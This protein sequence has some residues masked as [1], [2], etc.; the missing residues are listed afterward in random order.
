M[1][2]QEAVDFVNEKIQEALS[3]NHGTGET[4]YAAFEERVAQQLVD[5]A[6]LRHSTDNVT[7]QIVLLDE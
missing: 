4:P 3:D 2:D 7:V 5:E 6:L 1:T